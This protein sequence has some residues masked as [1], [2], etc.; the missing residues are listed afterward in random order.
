MGTSTET[1]E[2][3]ALPKRRQLAW[4]TLDS[5]RLAKLRE[6]PL[7]GEEMGGRPSSSSV[8]GLRDM[9][10]QLPQPVTGGPNTGVNRLT[11]TNIYYLYGD[12]RRAVR[13]AIE[14]N[15]AYFAALLDSSGYKTI[16]E[17]WGESMYQ[18]FCEEWAYRRFH[19]E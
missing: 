18:I 3:P 19:E 9:V 14:E 8:Y 1:T 17:H 4:Q 15:T 13:Q 6:R 2:L 5:D 7:A 16:A 11:W 10:C 12:D